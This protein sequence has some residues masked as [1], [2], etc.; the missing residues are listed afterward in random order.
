MLRDQTQ[1]P[2]CFHLGAK[3]GDALARGV[4]KENGVRHLGRDPHAASGAVLLKV[5]LVDGQIS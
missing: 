3:G 5:D 1:S 2:D 4:V